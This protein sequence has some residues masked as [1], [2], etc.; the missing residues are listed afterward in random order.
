M[1][2]LEESGNE[3]ETQ[4]FEILIGRGAWSQTALCTNSV[5]EPGDWGGHF[6][7]K[8]YLVTSVELVRPVLLF[9]LN[10]FII[11]VFIEV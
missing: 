2:N 9:N 11:N 8:T 10:L 7:C 6:T 1:A 4:V 5:N 3:H